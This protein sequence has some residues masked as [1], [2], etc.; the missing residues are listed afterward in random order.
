MTG[1][2]TT[3]IEFIVPESSA[4]SGSNRGSLWQRWD[5]HTHAPGTLFN[6]RFLGDWEEYLAKWEA[7]T[8]PVRALGITDY[9]LT[10]TYEQ[11]S[12]AKASGRLPECQLIFPNVEMR[13]SIGA[14]RSFVN[15]HL[16]VN[17]S[18]PNH[19]DELKRFLERLRFEAFKGSFC[20]RRDELIRLG[21][22][23][24]PNITGDNAALK[25][26]ANQFKVD[27][28]QLRREYENDEWA[29]ANVL[30]GVSGSTSDGTAGLRE[31]ADTTLREE[32]EKFAHIIFN[33]SPK[34]RDYWLGHGALSPD[35]IRHRYDGLKPCLH[36]SDAHSSADVGAPAENR[37]TWIKG[38]I[39]FESLKQ[40]CIDP[41]RAYVGE[42]PPGGATS[43]QTIDGINIA[44]AP[45]VKTPLLPLNAGLVAIIGPRGSGK[46]AL[47]DMIA[48]GCDATSERLSKQ[49]FLVRARHLLGGAT[50]A[51]T[52]ADGTHS[53]PHSLDAE[54]PLPS[55]EYPRAR[56]LSQKFVEDLCASDGVTDELLHEIERVVFEAHDNDEREGA[57]NFSE[58]VELRAGRHWQN[59]EREELILAN[60]SEQLGIEIDK[61]NLVSRLS[62]Q[63]REKT[64]LIA[65]YTADRAKLVARG[66]EERLVRLEE[67]TAAAQTVRG[68]VRMFGSREQ[69]FL[70]MRDE[71]ADFRSNRSPE[72]LRRMKERYA[73]SGLKDG[74]WERFR[75]TYSGDVD[76]A[77]NGGIKAARESAAARRGK[78]PTASS[79]D[80]NAPII[81]QD[82]DLTHLPLA[83]LEAEIGR[84]Q[85]LVGGDRV[86]AAQFA[87]VSKRINEETTALAR[88]QERLEDYRQAKQRIVHLR[89]VRQ[90]GYA[91]VFEAVLAVQS[92]LQ[93]LYAPL[94]ARI[95]AASGALTKLRFT[96]KRAADAEEWA[97]RGEA[98]LDLRRQGPFRG[99]GRLYKR[100]VTLLKRPWETGSV[101]DVVDA[102]AQFRE[103]TTAEDIRPMQK[104]DADFRAWAKGFAQWL[105][106]TDH[107]AIQYSVDYDGVDIRNLSPGT[108]GI[109]LLL[110]YL[111]LDEAD[112][113]PLIIDQPEENLDPKSIF[114]ELVPLFTEAKKTRQV[115]VITHNANL[116]VNTDADQIIIAD[117]GPSVDRQ[118][119]PITYTSGALEQHSIRNAVCRILEGGETA[120]RERARRLR[121][122]L[123]RR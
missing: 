75:L 52:W 103:E 4:C 31:A 5:P 11:V 93:E 114:D 6:D 37:Y 95:N 74:E 25:K 107:I 51:L 23:A 50:V 48:R 119:P 14:K 67:V 64:G 100:A 90:T 44:N 115:I 83:V 1:T 112:D 49:S 111:A 58:L 59:R 87:A 102:M 22:K 62:E 113:R 16:L 12:I 110:L 121:V 88:L 97:R 80:P 29:E 101:Q 117:A 9:Y 57:T 39:D 76:D 41:N 77:V 104:P 54:E 34:Q 28:N 47:A 36:G 68:Y 106:S 91:R 19:I 96:V 61:D 84:L 53:S 105:Y 94:M 7:A 120:F 63:V 43:S 118:L 3:T 2:T 10:D 71:I 26:G 40:A 30:I 79:G 86:I 56:Y 85:K 73:S 81:K 13:L 98:L 55:W 38:A 69:S 60:V 72:A 65:R 66:S 42:R 122:G 99:R 17:P 70:A 123:T 92:V 21:R 24:D 82:A 45:W 20:C 18:T 33:S 15:I 108:R 27:F 109:V 32:I 35:Q 89:A 78:P 8:P 46:T 116:V